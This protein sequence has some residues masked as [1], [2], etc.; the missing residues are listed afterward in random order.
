MTWGTPDTGAPFTFI[1]T[2]SELRNRCS[3]GRYAIWP[4]Q[5]STSCWPAS[6]DPRSKGKSRW[7]RGY[8]VIMGNRTDTLVPIVMF[9]TRPSYLHDSVSRESHG[10]SV[11]PVLPRSL[12]TFARAR[13]NSTCDI[14]VSS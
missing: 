4:E 9:R 10:K 14:V 5:T 2:H 6:R 8:D 3:E 13:I 7:G 11:V 1:G 12:L